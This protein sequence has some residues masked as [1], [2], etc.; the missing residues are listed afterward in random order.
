MCIFNIT[1]RILY[2]TNANTHTLPLR[3]TTYT[4]YTHNKYTLYI[5]IYT[6]GDGI[7]VLEGR[8]IDLDTDLDLS[9]PSII[10]SGT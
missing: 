10:A 9:S 5:H 8:E 3:Y 7:F 6:Y 4:Q 1:D 2:N